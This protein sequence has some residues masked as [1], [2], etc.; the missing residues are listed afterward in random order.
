[1]TRIQKTCVAAS[2][3]R[4]T[5]SQQE[6]KLRIRRNII[7][8]FSSFRY[9]FFVFFRQKFTQKASTVSLY[10]LNGFHVYTLH[11]HFSQ[12]PHRSLYDHFYEVQ[13]AFLLTNLTFL[14]SLSVP[15]TL[16][17]KKHWKKS[18]ISGNIAKTNLPLWK[19]CFF[20]HSI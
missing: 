10:I 1:M 16:T 19:W 3:C 20:T 13:M 5:H 17:R 18:A 7:M 14:F 11:T 8:L 15:L 2:A 9:S 4:T 12:N 6:K